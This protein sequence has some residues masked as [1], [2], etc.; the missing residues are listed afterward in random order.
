MSGIKKT[1][2]HLTKE[3]NETCR[4]EAAGP[5]VHISENP[6]MLPVPHQKQSV[7]SFTLS[8][9]SPHRKSFSFSHTHMHAH[10]CIHTQQLEGGAGFTYLAIPHLRAKS[11]PGRGEALLLREQG[12]RS[13]R[14]K[15]RGR[16][17]Q[18]CN[19]WS[20]SL[21]FAA[22]SC[23]LL[24]GRRVTEGTGRWAGLHPTQST[25]GTVG[26]AWDLPLSGVFQ[27]LPC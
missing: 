7:Y 17:S 16:I 4:A 21:S 22:F 13:R 8:F 14:G 5:R 1:A 24:L 25:S 9:C 15:S 2:V 26:H 12:M 11:D 23:L 6:R 19:S 10:A 18:F 3:Q 20:P 27:H